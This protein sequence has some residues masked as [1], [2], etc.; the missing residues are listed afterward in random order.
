MSSLI[1]RICTFLAAGLLGAE[2][3]GPAATMEKTSLVDSLDSGWV[4]SPGLSISFV[5]GLD[6]QGKALGVRLRQSGRMDTKPRNLKP[7]VLRISVRVQGSGRRD[8]LFAIL[9]DAY[10][11]NQLVPFGF[12]DFKD[13][14][15]L[16]A[17][18]ATIL[19][20]VR[21]EPKGLMFF[22]FYVE[23]AQGAESSIVIDTLEIT[24]GLPYIFPEEPFGIR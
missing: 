3:A 20:L 12:T 4:A 24:N 13:V 14:R 9:Q 2:P 16:N 8:R 17:D 1:A 19:Q 6:G 5:T 15:T 23:K 21:L 10:G 22:G 18:T 7:A 11:R